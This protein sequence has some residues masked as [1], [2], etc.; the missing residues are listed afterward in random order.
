ME[1]TD[2]RHKATPSLHD[3][4]S[5]ENIAREINLDPP[6]VNEFLLQTI[7]ETTESEISVL[8]SEPNGDD[9]NPHQMLPDHPPGNHQ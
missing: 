5:D 8:N 7:P 9:R 2:N 1:N 4:Y 6:E 3:A